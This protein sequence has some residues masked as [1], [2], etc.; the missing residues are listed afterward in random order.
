MR[1]ADPKPDS[2]RVES[3]SRV[4]RSLQIF[5]L[6]FETGEVLVERVVVGAVNDV[7]QLE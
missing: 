7:C 1:C 6:G 2:G 4:T 3:F 5:E